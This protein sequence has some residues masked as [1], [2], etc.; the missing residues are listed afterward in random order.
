[1]VRKFCI[2]TRQLIVTNSHFFLEQYQSGMISMQELYNLIHLTLLKSI[3]MNILYNCMLYISPY[4]PNGFLLIKKKKKD[5]PFRNCRLRIAVIACS[6]L[7]FLD[8]REFKRETLKQMNPS[9][10]EGSLHEVS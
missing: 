3:C 4:T 8:A 7:P 2:T 10:C 5:S 6:R 9:G 1:M